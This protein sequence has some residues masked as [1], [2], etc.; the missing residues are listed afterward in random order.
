MLVLFHRGDFL[1]LNEQEEIEQLKS[2]LLDVKKFDNAYNA[3]L[4]NI[5]SDMKLFR[6]IAPDEV[7]MIETCIKNHP[8]VTSFDLEISVQALTHV[9]VENNQKIL[10]LLDLLRRDNA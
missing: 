8:P 9:L 5:A 4:K 2:S 6:N 3:A 1:L 10:R 7:T